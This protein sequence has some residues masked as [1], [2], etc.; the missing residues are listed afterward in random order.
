MHSAEP[1]LTPEM[2]AELAVRTL[3][4]IDDDDEVSIEH[5]TEFY[6]SVPVAELSI[7]PARPMGYWS[8][9]PS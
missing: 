5:A 4:M 1:A 9:N 6:R 7:V 3:V 2:L 8:R